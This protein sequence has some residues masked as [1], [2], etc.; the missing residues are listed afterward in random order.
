M[1]RAL[2]CYGVKLKPEKCEMF[3][4]EVRYVGPLVSSEGVRIDPKELEADCLLTARTPQ[5]V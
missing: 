4:K 5:T 2:R 1:L 3:R